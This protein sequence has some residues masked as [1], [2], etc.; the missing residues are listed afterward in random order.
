MRV[1]V[2]ML[3]WM[4]WVADRCAKEQGCP[5]VCMHMDVCARTCTCMHGCACKG[6]HAYGFVSAC[7]EAP[8]PGCVSFARLHTHVCID[9]CVCLWVPAEVFLHTRVCM[10]VSVFARGCVCTWG[11]ERVQGGARP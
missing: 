7:K 1:H 6:V 10:H 3:V 8:G 2:S 9:A 4:G 5:R 11:C